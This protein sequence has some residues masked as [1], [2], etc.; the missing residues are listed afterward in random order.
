MCK[1]EAPEVVEGVEEA[2]AEMA[3]ADELDGETEEEEEEEEAAEEEETMEVLV[4]TADEV[5]VDHDSVVCGLGD[6]VSS[7]GP[8]DSAAT[9]VVVVS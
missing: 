6:A 7:V 5:E 2:M 4:A 3:V 9:V 8:L 1:E